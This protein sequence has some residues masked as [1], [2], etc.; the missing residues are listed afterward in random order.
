VAAWARCS[1]PA[2]KRSAFLTD[3]HADEP[4][5]R[6]RLLREA[7]AAAGL[8]HPGICTVH[9]TGET[10]DGRAYIVMQYVEGR[11]LADRLQDGTLP[12]REALTLA[13]HV[14][15]ALATAHAHGIVHRD[16]KPSNV[17]VTPSGRPKLVDFGVARRVM[18]SPEFGEAPTWS[19]ATIPGTIVGTPSYMSPEQVQQRRL[20]GRSDLF[21]LGVLLYECLGG[22]RP[23][24]GPSPVETIANVLYATPPAVSSLAPGLGPGHDELCWR[25]LA[26]QP[27][28]RF[29]SAGEVVGALRVLSAET[30]S[31][32]HGAPPATPR[33]RPVVTAWRSRTTWLLL[34]G[35]IVVALSAWRIDPSF[36]PASP[37]EAPPDAAAWFA[38]GTEALRQGAPLRARRALEEA[39]RVFPDFA[40]AHASFGDAERMAAAAVDAALADGLEAI[41]A[42][43]LVELGGTLMMARRPVEAEPHLKRALQLAGRHGARRTETRARIQLAAFYESEGRGGEALALVDEALPYARETRH[44]RFEL[45]ALNIAARV[46]L[47]ADDLVRAREVATDVVGVAES[48]NAGGQLVTGLNNLATVMMATGSLP[49]ALRLRERGGHRRPAPRRRDPPL[50]PGEPRRAA[51]AAGTVRRRRAAAGGARRRHRGAR[52]CLH[53]VALALHVRAGARGGDGA[54]L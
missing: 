15:D 50:Q 1:S 18:L 30:P 46:H 21:S 40:L 11:S 47:A 53:G 45:D 37:P 29:Q 49:D 41:G 6:R 17:I 34:L 27:A 10:P 2:T 13:S 5:A 24:D 12:A 23:F 36:T 44:R 14:A 22:R 19:G 43:G 38:R 39:V 26:K 51:R 7:Q 16:L 33:K 54:P 31:P 4:D 35:A 8:D 28:D 9:E 3:H 32:V 48:L 25:L 42:D 52:G 20:D